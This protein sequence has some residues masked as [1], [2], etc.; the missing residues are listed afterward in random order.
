MPTTTD[1]SRFYGV[2]PACV[3]PFKEDESIDFLALESH[4]GDYLRAGVHGISI[5]GSQGE[6]FA[7][8]HTERIALMER[9]VQIVAGRVP[10]Y[11]GTGAVTTRESIALIQAA[12]A[13]GANV[14][15]VI[16]PYFIS[17]SAAELAE[18]YRAV[19]R[20]T[21]LPVIL[22]NNP[23]RTGVNLR[24]SQYREL[25]AIENIIGIKDSSGDLT[26]LTE[27]LSVTDHTSRVFVGRD[28]LILSAI[29][30]GGAGAI[31]PAA[32]VFPRT[33]V[34]LYTAIQ[35]GDLPEARRLSD[36]LAPLRAAW[37]LGSFPVVIKEAMVLAGRAA[38]PA[39]RPILA[40][41]DQQRDS[42]RMIIDRL[43]HDELG[44]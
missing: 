40:L 21:R 41:S 4:I 38:G 12:E 37:A 11:A 23:P 15:M 30:H 20:A 35:A 17:P 32:S 25:H 28:T 31:S 43:Q 13:A 26:Q 36:L 9:A 14:A 1:A 27:Y 29:L 10:V 6:F 8:S 18:H 22:Y 2:I 3:T 42:L 33:V 34:R 16:T 39:R 24:P 44:R 7:L 19:A 5:A